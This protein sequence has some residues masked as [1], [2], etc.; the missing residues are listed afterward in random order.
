M[1]PSTDP[2]PVHRDVSDLLVTLHTHEKQQGG[3]AADVVPLG[4]C[5][6][7]G[8][9]SADMGS[10]VS[11]STLRLGMSL[12]RMVYLHLRE[13]R[14]SIIDALIS[15]ALNRSSGVPKQLT[16]ASVLSFLLTGKQ[17]V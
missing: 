14:A 8:V 9:W 4:P 12:L 1:L 15:G 3:T 6:G 13:S 5:V 11:R 7:G 2:D 17:H 16:F 10:M